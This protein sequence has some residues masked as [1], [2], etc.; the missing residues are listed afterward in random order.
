MDKKH[1]RKKTI[2]K[3]VIKWRNEGQRGKNEVSNESSR[4]KGWGIS[5]KCVREDKLESPTG[6]QQLVGR[7]QLPFLFP[8]DPFGF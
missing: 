5:E 4:G 3:K 8:L 1:T 6:K 2:M 7:R